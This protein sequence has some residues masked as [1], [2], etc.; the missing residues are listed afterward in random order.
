MIQ[1]YYFILLVSRC[2]AKVVDGYCNTVDQSRSVLGFY[3]RSLEAISAFPQTVLK[4]T[5][6][7]SQPLVKKVSTKFNSS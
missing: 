4:E 2:L 3:G 6:K 5:Q 1:V 7:V